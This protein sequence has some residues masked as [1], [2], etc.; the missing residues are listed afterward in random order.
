MKQIAFI[1]ALAFSLLVEPSAGR[2]AERLVVATGEWAPYVSEQMEDKG[3]MIQILSDAFDVMGVEVEYV[4]YPWRRCY[5]SVTAGRVWAGFPYSRTKERE[6]EVLF[7]DVI[8]Y[9]ITKFFVYGNSGPDRYKGL[10][11][12]KSFRIGGVIGY[13]YEADFKRHGLNVDYASKE[14]SAVEMLMM[15]RT[16]ALPLNELVG[17]R[18]IQNHFSKK[19]QGFRVLEPPYSK[20][21]LHLIVSRRHP[22]GKDLLNRFNDALRQVKDDYIYEGVLERYLQP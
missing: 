4:F 19:S 1:A 16:D 21:D 15:G 3:F 2:G 22:G 8:S 12:L 20:D 9:S 18:L 7:S 5:E 6:G 13:F 17:W 14:I 10:E 11:S